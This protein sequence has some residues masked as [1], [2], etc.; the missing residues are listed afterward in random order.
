[1]S[2]WNI[3]IY[4]ENTQIGFGGCV[5]HIWDKTGKKNLWDGSVKSENESL[6][7]R[8]KKKV[9]LTRLNEYKMPRGNK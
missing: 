3:T 4:R 8:G 6:E 9:M 2:L 7:V 1:M 5:E